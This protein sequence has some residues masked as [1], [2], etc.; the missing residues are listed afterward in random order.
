MRSHSGTAEGVSQ[1]MVHEYYA[2]HLQKSFPQSACDSRG[3]GLLTGGL[4][5]ATHVLVVNGLWL[6]VVCC[7][8]V[9]LIDIHLLAIIGD[10]IFVFSWNSSL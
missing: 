8:L 4:F 6:I 9:S 10:E 2:L 5:D 7:R 3:R 1:P